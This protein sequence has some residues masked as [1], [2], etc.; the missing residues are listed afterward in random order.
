M[1]TDKYAKVVNYGPGPGQVTVGGEEKRR[2]SLLVKRFS[3]R[4]KCDEWFQLIA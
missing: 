4:I 2:E 1:M 3:K